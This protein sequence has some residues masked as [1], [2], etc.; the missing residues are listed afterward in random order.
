MGLQELHRLTKDYRYKLRIDMQVGGKWNSVWYRLFKV[1]YERSNYKLE[2]A[3]GFKT[4]GTAQD[5]L[6]ELVGAS[7]TTWDRDNDPLKNENIAEI[8]GGGFW[9]TSPDGPAS[10][11]SAEM[12]WKGLDAITAT[13]MFLECK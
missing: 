1:S 9:Y 3:S 10:L 13:R 7:F 2:R 12:S 4:D 5:A 8:Y 11:N 6:K